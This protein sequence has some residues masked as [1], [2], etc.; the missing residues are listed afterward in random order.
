M[1]Y[2]VE[3]NQPTSQVMTVY[4]KMEKAFEEEYLLCFELLT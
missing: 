4:F 3:S 2:M 1:E